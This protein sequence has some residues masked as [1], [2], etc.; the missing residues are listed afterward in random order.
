MEIY[1]AYDDFQWRVSHN[2]KRE[3]FAPRSAEIA[4]KD[5]LF[6]LTLEVSIQWVVKVKH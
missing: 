3:A 2:A 4:R 1:G 6:L 5:Q